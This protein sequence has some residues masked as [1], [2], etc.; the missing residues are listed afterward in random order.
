MKKKRPLD[1]KLEVIETE[2]LELANK[3]DEEAA[4]IVK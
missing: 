4:E 3:Q 1:P 2:M